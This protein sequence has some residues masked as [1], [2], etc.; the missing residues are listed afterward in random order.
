MTNEEFTR[1]RAR[2]QNLVKLTVLCSKVDPKKKTSRHIVRKFEKLRMPIHEAQ[3]DQIIG[4]LATN[5]LQVLEAMLKFF[6]T[7]Q[8]S[9]YWLSGDIHRVGD[10]I[11]ESISVQLNREG[12]QIGG[13]RFTSDIAFR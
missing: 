10:E 11:A 7:G 4:S 9:Y 1:S 5:R 6:Q 13:N 12:V 8:E 2:L 3:K